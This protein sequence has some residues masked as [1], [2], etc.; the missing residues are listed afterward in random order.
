MDHSLYDGRLLANA[1]FLRLLELKQEEP[2]EISKQISRAIIEKL[3]TSILINVLTEVNVGE[4]IKQEY[5][6]RAHACHAGLTH[7]I[8]FMIAENL[9]K[10]GLTVE[11]PGYL[12]LIVSCGDNTI[13]VKER[14]IQ[15]EL[16]ETMQNLPDKLW[17]I[18][19][20]HIVSNPKAD[21]LDIYLAQ[22]IPDNLV[23]HI[24]KI[25]DNVQV[26]FKNAGLTAT[27]IQED[28][29]FKVKLPPPKNYECL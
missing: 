17:K 1:R 26:F 25:V 11:S 16:E 29:I 22:Y 2:V 24:K 28:T 3:N 4:M 8:T 20:D 19:L 12:V 6:L 21:E 18:L 10:W 23:E 7:A 13:S 9:R 14:M 5:E 27:Y 15:I